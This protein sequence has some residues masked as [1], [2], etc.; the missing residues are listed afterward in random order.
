ML[1]HTLLLVLS[2]LM[3]LRLRKFKSSITRI[4]EQER[5]KGNPAAQD[6]LEVMARTA[7]A[8][9]VSLHR[10]AGGSL[11]GHTKSNPACLQGYTPRC[12]E[13]RERH[14]CKATLQGAGNPSW[15]SP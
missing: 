15:L 11:R 14:V 12:R 1:E 7:G 6:F 5:A 10:A 3:R 8:S 13:P 4:L 9:D 2:C